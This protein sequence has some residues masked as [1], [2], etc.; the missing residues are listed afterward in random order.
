MNKKSKQ[1]K[2]KKGTTPPS[3]TSLTS[4]STSAPCHSPPCGSHPQDRILR[5]REY[6][7]RLQLH[8]DNVFE[9]LARDLRLTEAGENLLFDFFF[10]ADNEIDFVDYLIEKGV[11]YSDLVK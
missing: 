4:T 10:N 3:A 7:Q 2:S 6:S 5:D 11:D 1:L 8:V 9:T